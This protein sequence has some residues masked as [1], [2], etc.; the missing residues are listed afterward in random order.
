M[1]HNAQIARLL[2]TEHMEQ[3]AST[4]KMETLLRSL[5]PGTVPSKG[6]PVMKALPDIIGSLEAE[7]NQHFVFEE[8][9]LFPRLAEMG[10]ANIGNFLK[11][12]HD[13]IREVGGQVIALGK[14]ALAE[15]FNPSSWA[16]FYQNASELSEWVFQ[17]VQKEEMGLLPMVDM[18]LEGDED[19]TLTEA[20]LASR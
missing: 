19:A 8:N 13:V 4:E 7:I 16:D 5:K 17:H 14:T 18:L 20:Y 2:H 9:V 12:E 11:S 6:D 15:G 1:E 10:E 3:I